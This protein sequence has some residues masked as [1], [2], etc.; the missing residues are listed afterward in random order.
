MSLFYLMA[1]GISKSWSELFEDV[2]SFTS[3]FVLI[4]QVWMKME[5]L[6]TPCFL[7]RDVALQPSHL[8]ANVHFNSRPS[9]LC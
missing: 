8:D 3:I 6:C 2:P 1:F 4:G 5:Y 7:Q 9:M